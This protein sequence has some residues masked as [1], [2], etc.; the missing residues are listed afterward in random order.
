VSRG[1]WRDL[2]AFVLGL[3]I[4]GVVVILALDEYRTH[5]RVEASEGSLLT[6]IV[7]AVVG[8]LAVYLGV[9]SNGGGHD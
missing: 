5:G 6:G 9:R 1:T 2:T 4:A 3:G 8:A 7:G